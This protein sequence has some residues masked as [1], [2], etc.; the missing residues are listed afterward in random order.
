M[1]PVRF[2]HTSDVHLDT[3]FSGSGFPSRLGDRKE[4]SDPRHI[5]PHHG[6]CPV[7]RCRF[8]A[9]RRRSL[10]NW[11]ASRPTPLNFSGNSSKAWAESAYSFLPETT[12]RASRDLPTG[13][14]PGPPMS[15]SSMRRNSSPSSFPDL[16]VR[17]TGFGFTHT[18]MDAHHFQRLPVL[19]NEFFNIVLTHGSDVSRVPAGKSK[20]GPFTIEEIAGKN[21]QYCALGH[22]HQQHRIPNPVDETQIWYSGIPEGRGWDEEGACGYL[23]GRNRK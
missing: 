11:S 23:A 6:G 22:Y 14:N 7:L 20:H 19:S 17:V 13:K 1:R 8:C 15:T 21:V 16:G 2:I 10:S 9:H 12:I 5:P 3:S 4:G 18:Q